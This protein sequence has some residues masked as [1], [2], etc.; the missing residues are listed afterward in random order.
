MNSAAKL[1]KTP[2]FPSL[3]TGKLFPIP[4]NSW[5]KTPRPISRL[6]NEYSL[7]KDQDLYMPK[8]KGLPVVWN[9]SH[10][11]ASAWFPRGRNSWPRRDGHTLSDHR[12]RR[13]I[14][15]E[16]ARYVYSR[17]L[18]LV[19]SLKTKLAYEFGCKVMQ[20]STLPLPRNRKIIP[21]P[22]KLLI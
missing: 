3:E 5:F 1:C 9:R 18:L 20:N 7:A 21:N 19:P 11:I 12:S 16:S 15:S 17:Y 6:M 10:A 4:A 2:H 14:E 13:W 8:G 22:C